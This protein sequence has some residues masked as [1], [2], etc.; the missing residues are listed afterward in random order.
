MNLQPQYPS[1]FGGV[2]CPTLSDS[3]RLENQFAV[4][5]DLMSD[6]K[7]HTLPAIEELTGYPQASISAQ[8]RHCR[9]PK[10]GAHTVNRRHV[11][12]GLFEYQLIV[13]EDAE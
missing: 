5:F 1:R 7:W 6:G 12:N 10:F 11:R 8:L 3:T 2:G 13:N 9:K 4:I